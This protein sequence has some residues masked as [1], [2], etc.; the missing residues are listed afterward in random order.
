[1]SLERVAEL[2]KQIASHFVEIRQIQS[3]IQEKNKEI[4]EKYRQLAL[5]DQVN[6]GVCTRC[7]EY[8]SREDLYNDSPVGSTSSPDMLCP[9]CFAEK[10]Y[11]R[12]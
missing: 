10:Y 9:A 4:R 1:M 12:Q 5:K 6:Y 7:D 3:L 8:F 11:W 2:K